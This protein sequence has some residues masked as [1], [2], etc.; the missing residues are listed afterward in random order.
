MKVKDLID[1]VTNNAFYSIWDVDEY[2][3]DN[4][5]EWLQ[6]VSKDNKSIEY[7]QEVDIND[8][9]YYVAATVLYKCDDG[10]VGI[11]GVYWVPDDNIEYI[12]LEELCTA[13][14]Y[15]LENKLVYVPK[16]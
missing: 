7:L 13:K 10:V 5:N 2:L 1:I 14:E 6:P 12:D 3:H 15:V 8:E 16:N 4:H 11:H 9:A